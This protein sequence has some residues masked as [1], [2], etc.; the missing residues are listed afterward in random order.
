MSRCS[1]G[2]LVF[3]LSKDEQ[4]ARAQ[5]NGFFDEG[6]VATWPASIS[7][8]S[9]T[10]DI[11]RDSAR[12]RSVRRCRCRRVRHFGSPSAFAASRGCP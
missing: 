8:P 1:A 12:R 11:R 10:S 4:I 7:L 2:G 3:V 5:A 9:R 6:K